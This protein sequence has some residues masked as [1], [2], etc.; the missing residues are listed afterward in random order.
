VT[1]YKQLIICKNP[2]SNLPR[3]YDNTDAEETNMSPVKLCT[4]PFHQRK[5]I[6]FGLL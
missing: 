6:T 1:N 2:E 4:A 3:S 5:R